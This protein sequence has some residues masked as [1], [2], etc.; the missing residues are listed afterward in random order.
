MKFRDVRFQVEYIQDR[1][2]GI[3]LNKNDSSKAC[4]ALIRRLKEH[5]ALFIFAGDKSQSPTLKMRVKIKW[6]KLEIAALTEQG[7]T[8]GASAI[9]PDKDEQGT[10]QKYNK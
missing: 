9:F 7:Y 2:V 8:Y 6:D 5:S 3:M 1:F 4:Q 10:T